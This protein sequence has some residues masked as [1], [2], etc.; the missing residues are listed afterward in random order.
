MERIIITPLTE[1]C[2][3]IFLNAIHYKRGGAAVGQTGTGKTETIKDLC[4]A[5]G[6]RCI[7]F[8]CSELVDYVLIS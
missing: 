2:L 4:K 8:N 5:T 3:I 1:R 6:Q 7:L